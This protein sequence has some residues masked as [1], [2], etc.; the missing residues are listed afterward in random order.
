MSKSR[1]QKKELLDDYRE[2]INEAKA[3]YFI[4]AKSIPASE[5]IDVKK[6]LYDLNSSYNVIKNTI[7][8]LALEKEGIDK[9][10][11]IDSGQHGVVFAHEDSLSEAAKIIYEFI[12]KKNK[13][14]ELGLEIKAGILD[15]EPIAASQ[16][17][18]LAQLPSREQLLGQV[19]GTL[20]APISGFVNALADNIKKFGYALNAVKTQKSEA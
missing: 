18:E 6:E 13:E 20:N 11:N 9:P 10:D 14:K 4:T 12:K 5:I 19:V 17:N 16:V 2:K 15:K 3:L 1:E 7:F 8:Q